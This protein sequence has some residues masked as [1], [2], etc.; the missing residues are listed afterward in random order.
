MFDNHL[1]DKGAQKLLEIIE[2]FNSTLTFINLNKNKIESKEMIEAILDFLNFLL[3]IFL[4]YKC[5]FKAK[6]IF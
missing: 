5:I 6:S 4:G 2:E 1:T 3:I